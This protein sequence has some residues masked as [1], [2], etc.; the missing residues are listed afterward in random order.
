[1]V[2]YKITNLINGKIYVGQTTKTIDQRF[3]EHC[4]TT[5]GCR[6]L[7]NAIKKYGSG[8]FSIEI[9]EECDNLDDLNVREKY[10][11]KIYNSLV[12]NG[13]NIQTGG[14]NH[15]VTDETRRIISNKVS[16]KNNPFYGKKHSAETIEYLRKINTGKKQSEETRQKRANKE[17]GKLNHF[18]GKTHSSESRKKISETRKNYTGNKH[19]RCKKVICVETGKVYSY[20][21]LAQ[22][23]TGINESHICNCCKGKLKTAGGFHWKY[24][25]EECNGTREKL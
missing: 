25:E 22:I 19:P 23:E 16:G 14:E 18:Y 11:I 6:A 13:Y 4:K 2:I 15:T 7:K 3:K 9:V 17:L 8:N 21:R 5:S 24:F 12:P 10:W 20:I 1:M